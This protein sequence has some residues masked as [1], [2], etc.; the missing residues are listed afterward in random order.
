VLTAIDARERRPID[1]AEAKRRRGR[2]ICPACNAPV[3][4]KLGDIKAWHFA[5]TAHTAC[6]GTGRE[7]GAHADAKREIAAALVGH[8]LVS[9]VGTE[10]SSGDR[11]ADVFV[12]LKSGQRVAIEVQASAISAA[13]VDAR[14]RSYAEQGVFAAWVCPYT[15]PSFDQKKRFAATVTPTR[16]ERF[17]S[18]L[19]RE[20]IYLWA[21]G[22]RVFCASMVPDL[23]LCSGSVE[24]GW[25]DPDE[26]PATGADDRV[27]GRAWGVPRARPRPSKK[28]LLVLPRALHLL[29]DFGPAR[30]SPFVWHG[31]ICGGYALWQDRAGGEWDAPLIAEISDSVA[32]WRIWA[33]RAIKS[34]ELK[35]GCGDIGAARAAW[36]DATI[37]RQAK[38][39]KARRRLHK[40][41]GE[42]RRAAPSRM[43]RQTQ[44]ADRAPPPLISDH[45]LRLAAALAAH[46]PPPQRGCADSWYAER[47]R[48]IRDHAH[49]LTS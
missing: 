23:V 19:H 38:A 16:T 43:G 9:L 27:I 5:H 34:G 46:G 36:A 13:E 40:A 17:M 25:V 26:M 47:L 48:I 4:A 11:R 10:V 8:P 29:D 2:Y 14:T 44:E 32:G 12:W 15:P 49:P 24:Y 35:P 7:S 21:G 37:A 39:K 3:V 22:A 18:A 33:A 1:A 20:R 45:D 6:D 30:R 41:L 31:R 28:S 42:S